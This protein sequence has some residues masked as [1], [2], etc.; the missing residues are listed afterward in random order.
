MTMGLSGLGGLLVFLLA[1]G[2]G[3]PVANACPFCSYDTARVVGGVCPECGGDLLADFRA[4]LDAL[5]AADE[6]TREEAERVLQDR[7]RMMSEEPPPQ[8]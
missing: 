6:R 2:S 4:K 7:Y 3:A 8:H 1:R 5:V